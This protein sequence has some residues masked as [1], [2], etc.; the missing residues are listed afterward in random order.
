MGMGMAPART[1]DSRPQSD[2]TIKPAKA[3]PVVPPRCMSICTC[4]KNNGGTVLGYLRC[5]ISPSSRVGS[6]PACS[7]LAD[8]SNNKKSLG[9]PPPH[10]SSLPLLSCMQFL[11]PI[12]SSPFSHSLFWFHFFILFP[13]TSIGLF[14]PAPDSYRESA[15]LVRPLKNTPP[16]PK[17]GPS[18]FLVPSLSALLNHFP[19]LDT[20]TGLCYPRSRRWPHR[21]GPRVASS[22]CNLASIGTTRA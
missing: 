18:Q 7:G 21:P 14:C 16:P 22:S 15:L 1:W 12:Q 13:I 4:K 6:Q 17:R 5:F 19:F 8:C 9:A 3:E 10:A 2:H 11:S 20:K